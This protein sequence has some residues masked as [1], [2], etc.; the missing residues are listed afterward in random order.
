MSGSALQ[1]APPAAEAPSQG[2][3]II[4]VGSLRLD[5]WTGSAQLAGRQLRLSKT[6]LRVLLYLAQRA[7]RAVPTAELLTAVWGSSVPASGTANRVKS[8]I[9]RLR[10]KIELDPGHPHY[11]LTVRGGGYLIPKLVL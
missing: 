5:V 7:G 11:I 8:C 4:L 3:L 2:V 1:S 9:R 6:E 10:E